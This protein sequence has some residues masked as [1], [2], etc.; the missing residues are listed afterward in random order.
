MV[1]MTDFS[2]RHF[3]NLIEVPYCAGHLPFW[4]TVDLAIKL[5][6]RLETSPIWII[7]LIFLTPAISLTPGK[8][9]LNF[10]INH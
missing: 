4:F 2:N 5:K 9:S 7:L 8:F 6:E 10:V 1:S 3:D